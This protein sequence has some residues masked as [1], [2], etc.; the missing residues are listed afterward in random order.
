MVGK[1]RCPAA[2]AVTRVSPHLKY[3][4]AVRLL[5]AR[6]SRLR[7]STYRAR[8]PVAAREHATSPAGVTSRRSVPCRS[9]MPRLDGW[10]RTPSPPFCRLDPAPSLANRFIMGRAS[11]MAR[12]F[13]S[14]P[15]D[16]TPRWTPCPPVAFQ[17]CVD[18]A[19]SLDVSAGSSFVPVYA[20]ANRSRLEVDGSARTFAERTAQG[21]AA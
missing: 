16:S 10:I 11:I 19:P 9:H 8:Y 13:S 6:P 5:D 18:L 1:P 15:T 20:R 17:Q 4:S 7:H 3:H 2:R 14:S 21:P 12:Y